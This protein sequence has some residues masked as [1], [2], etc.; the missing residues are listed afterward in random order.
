MAVPKSLRL[1]EIWSRLADAP[2][3]Q[4]GSEVFAQLANI[5][6]EVEDRTGIPFEPR[7]W[8]TDGRMY[9]PQDDSW[10]SVPDH[11]QVRRFRS[12]AHNI[13]IGANGSISIVRLDD[14]VELA[15][16]GADGRGVWDLNG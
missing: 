12:R 7:R 3:A 16:P 4:T 15:K 2:P 6:N 14:T 13:Y 10:R 1:L 5:M 11:P 9:P 8:Q